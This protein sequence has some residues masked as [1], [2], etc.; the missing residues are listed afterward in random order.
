MTL[1]LKCK[2]KNGSK[3]FLLTHKTFAHSAKFKVDSE[4]QSLTRRDLKT[5]LI[6]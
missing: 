5:G 6:D 2:A 1:N 4:R 3:K